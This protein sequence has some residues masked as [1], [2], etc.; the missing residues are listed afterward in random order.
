MIQIT[1]SDAALDA[2]V[3]LEFVGAVS[4]QLLSEC[5]LGVGSSAPSID[6]TTKV[7]CT[8]KKSDNA[9][10]LVVHYDAANFTVNLTNTTS[11]TSANENVQYETS[12]LAYLTN[13][14]AVKY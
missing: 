5:T 9:S 11:G 1:N 10:F 13:L 3:T 8:I 4:M 2:T 14:Y 6:G 12:A 7:N